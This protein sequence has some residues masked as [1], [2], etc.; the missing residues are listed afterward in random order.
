MQTLLVY[1][2]GGARGNPGPAAIGV[3]IVDSQQKTLGGFGKQIGETTN[4]VAEYTAVVEA[5]HWLLAHKKEVLC[6]SVRFFLDSQL[7]VSQMNGIYKIKNANLHKLYMQIKKLEVLF[8]V[9]VE[10]RHISRNQNK[11]AD[12]YVN[13][14]L[15]N[16]SALPYN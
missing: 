9:P 3:H 5:F 15:D 4:N 12:A 8:A 10:Y 14:A 13:M 11:Y 6:T 2:D 7:V 16:K 1:T